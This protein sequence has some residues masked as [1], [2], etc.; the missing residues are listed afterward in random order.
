MGPNVSDK[1]PAQYGDPTHHAQA[2]QKL[3][4]EIVDLSN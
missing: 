3:M 4:L 1:D 2:A